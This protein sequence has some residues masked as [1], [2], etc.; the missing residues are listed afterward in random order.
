MLRQLSLDA[1]L[2]ALLHP[3]AVA[4]SPAVFWRRWVSAGTCRPRHFP[5]GLRFVK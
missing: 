5:S 2:E 3:V 1:R 4:F